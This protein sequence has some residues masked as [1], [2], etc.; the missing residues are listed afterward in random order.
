MEEY[1][2]ILHGILL[3]KWHLANLARYLT[4]QGYKVINI[5]Y[6]S[7]KYPLEKLVNI[8]AQDITSK[9]TEIAVNNK[10][11]EYTVNF[12]GYSMGGL[13]LRAIFNSSNNHHNNDNNNIIRKNLGKVL[14][15]A[16]PNHGSEVADFFKN[17]WLYKKIFGPAGRQLT[18]DQ[19][20]I[21][22]LFTTIDYPLGV[23]AGNISLNY[24][25]SKLINQPNDGKV[26]IASTKV[27]G[28][29]D[30]ITLPASHTWLP[31]NKKVQYQ[32]VYFLQ[33]G[34]FYRTTNG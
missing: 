16:T 25:F 20:D 6:P 28:M 1:V 33:H 34:K 26:S 4:K 22:H 9:L 19:T 2:I 30:H 3:G 8:V 29:Q 11:S 31:Y 23:I 12:I 21:Q 27:D 14:L 5:G 13:I 24:F 15:L 17:N 32:T 10:S 7:T 18:T